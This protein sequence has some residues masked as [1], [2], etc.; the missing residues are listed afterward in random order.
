MQREHTTVP[1]YSTVP[2]LDVDPRVY[3]I[4]PHNIVGEV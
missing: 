2:C 1:C 3:D 4:T